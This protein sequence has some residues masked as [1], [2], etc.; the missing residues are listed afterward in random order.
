MCLGVRYRHDKDGFADLLLAES[1]AMELIPGAPYK[2]MSKRYSAEDTQRALALVRSCLWRVKRMG[3]KPLVL[4]NDENIER[5]L[6]VGRS[7][8][9]L[10]GY[11]VLSIERFFAE[12]E[13]LSFEDKCDQ[14]VVNLRHEL[15]H[16][17]DILTNPYAVGVGRDLIFK[18]KSYAVTESGIT[19]GCTEKDAPFVY[20]RLKAAGLIEVPPFDRAA[21]GFTLSGAGYGLADKMRIV[22]PSGLTNKA[23]EGPRRMEDGKGGVNGQETQAPQVVNMTNH[24]YGTQAVT[25]GHHSTITQTITTELPSELQSLASLLAGVEGGRLSPESSL[26]LQ[27]AAQGQSKLQLAA[28]AEK[29]AEKSEAHRSLLSEFLEEVAKKLA[30]KGVEAGANAASWLYLHGP[31]LVAALSFTLQHGK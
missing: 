18:P 24:V 17:K 15:D 19:Y 7:H 31:T 23:V 21:E 11:T 12:A 27:Q 8:E 6:D 9:R 3:L 26:L 30:E 16:G 4:T 29:V 5:V 10:E 14:T 25:T 1:L 28:S 22:P 13:A 20:S 2:M